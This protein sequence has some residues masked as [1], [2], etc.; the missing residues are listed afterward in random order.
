MDAKLKAKWIE[1]LRSGKYV[2]TTEWCFRNENEEGTMCYC[3]M[4]VLA[5]I[6][7]PTRR[8]YTMWMDD[9]CLPKSVLEEIGL[10]S[11]VQSKVMNMNDTYGNSFEDIAKYIEE[12]A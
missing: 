11:E 5:D 8:Y 3:A 9:V 10:S 4:G 12:M 2:Q 7:D 6:I 1:A